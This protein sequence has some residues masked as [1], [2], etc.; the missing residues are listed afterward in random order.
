MY[1]KKINIKKVNKARGRS[2]SVK[3]SS[4][5]IILTLLLLTSSVALAV[6]SSTVGVEIAKLEDD[7]Y[8][9]STRYN[10]LSDKLIRS[11]SLMSISDKAEEMGFIKPSD[12][13]YTNKDETIAKLP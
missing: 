7:E 2:W 11:N 13:V 5:L 8:Q 9:L 6:E 12:I 3:I 4:L 1:R 10:D